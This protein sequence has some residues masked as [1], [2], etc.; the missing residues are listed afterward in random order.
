[1]NRISQ[2]IE[3]DAALT[4]EALTEYLSSFRNEVPVLADAMRYSALGGGKRIRPF[5]VLEFCR[6][7]GGDPEKAL[8]LACALEMIH[9]YSLIHDDLPCMDDD[10]L[11]RGKPTTH[12]KFGEANALL[13]GDALLT[14]AFETASKADLDPQSVVKAIRY[15]ASAAGPD[16]M[17]GGQMLD[18]FAEDNEINEAALRSLYSMKTGA[19]IRCA[20]VLGCIAANADSE[21]IEAAVSYAEKIGL[22]FEIIDD[23]LDVTSTEGVLGKPIGSDLEQNKTTFLTFMCIDDARKTAKETTKAAEDAIAGYDREGVLTDFA[24]Y[25]LARNK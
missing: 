16:G 8:P 5:L 25:L 17:V 13:A 4:E 10:D 19:L 14:Y 9:C 24:E 1:M 20:C 11:R 7:F 3:Q 21:K 22:T 15:L 23:I 18:L 6:V 2:I 12:V